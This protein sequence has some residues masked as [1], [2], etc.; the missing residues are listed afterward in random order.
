MDHLNTAEHARRK[1]LNDNLRNILDRLRRGFADV[2][3]PFGDALA[4]LKAALATSAEQEL[5]EQ[6]RTLQ[7]NFGTLQGLAANLPAIEQAE[8]ACDAANIDENEFTDHRYDDLLFSFD[9]LNKTYTKQI[10][11]IQNQIQAAQT[12][13]VSAEMLQEFKESFDH[14]DNDKNGTLSRLE[15]KSALSGL[16]VVSLDFEGGDKKFDGIF[17]KVSGGTDHVNFNQFV[18]YMVSITADDTSESQ[19]RDSFDTLA[20]GK[21]F[22][23]EKD[24]RV[25]QLNDQQI[26]YLTSTLPPKA[27]IEGGYDYRAWLNS[28]Y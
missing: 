2:A 26:Q 20:G 17:Q 19:I 21:D 23:T 8:A 25:G 12:A 13:D 15:F 27:G 11:F 3:N 9:R 14:F 24:M 5:E 10:T 28:S 22:L 16:G 6:L 4:S 7:H 18:E 1:Q